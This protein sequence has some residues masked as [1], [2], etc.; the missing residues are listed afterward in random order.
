MLSFS[1]T[2][3]RVA[4]LEAVI[5]VAVQRAALALAAQPEVALEEAGPAPTKAK[6]A[7]EGTLQPRIRALT[8]SSSSPWAHVHSEPRAQVPW[9]R[10]TMQSSTLPQAA[11]PA[12]RICRWCAWCS[13]HLHHLRQEYQHRKHCTAPRGSAR[14]AQLALEHAPECPT[15][16]PAMPANAGRKSSPHKA[17]AGPVTL[18]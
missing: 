7:S 18:Q 11:P 9:A 13:H 8:P 6:R 2:G 15:V 5:G 1:C 4:S 3:S 12:P 10:C 17:T 16:L 14:S